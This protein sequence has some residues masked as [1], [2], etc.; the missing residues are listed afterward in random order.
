MELKNLEKAS[1]LLERVKQLDKEIIAIDKKANLILTK[2]ITTFYQLPY[3][4][5]TNLIDTVMIE[6]KFI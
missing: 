1:K 2:S 5:G 4:F 6:G 3:N